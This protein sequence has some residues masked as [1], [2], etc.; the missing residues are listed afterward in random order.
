MADMTAVS[1][2]IRNS[3][4]SGF[5]TKNDPSARRSASS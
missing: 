2:R 5:G 3:L 1:V 4:C